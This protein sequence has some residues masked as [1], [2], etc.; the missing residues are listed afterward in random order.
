MSMVHDLPPKLGLIAGSGLFPVMVAD[1]ARARGIQVV[2]CA[3][4]GHADAALRA[5]VDTFYWVGVARLGQWSRKLRRAGVRRAVMA[6]RV[7][8]TD[9]YAPLRLLRN[10]PDWRSIK[11]WYR[12]VHDKRNDTLLAA[13]ADE[14][15]RDGITLENSV[16]YLPEALARVGVMGKRQPSAAARKDVEFAWGIAKEMGRLDVG[17]S[18]AVKEQEVIAV[19]AIEG[20]DAMI[21]RAGQ[22]CRSGGWSLVKVAKP[23][24][25]MRFDVPTVGPDTIK[26]LHAAKGI[27]LAVEAGKTLMIDREQILQEADRLGITVMGLHA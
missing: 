4:R 22:L 8:K 3:F 14:L 17:Q 9:M 6:G 11:L 12:H 18:I 26:N 23:H 27:A 7:R 24:Q 13:V 16:S 20:T 15:Q 10:L 19:E 5:H 1:A 2:A 21:Q 25:D